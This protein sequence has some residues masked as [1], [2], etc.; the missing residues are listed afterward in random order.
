MHSETTPIARRTPRTEQLGLF[1]SPP[2]LLSP[3]DIFQNA[4]ATLLSILR[5]DRKIARKPARTHGRVIGEYHSMWA[6]TAPEG[7][8]TALGIENDGTFTG[9]AMLSNSEL[10]DREKAGHSYCPDSRSD[11]KRIPVINSLGQADFVLLLR[12]Y[13]REDKVV[14]D[15]TGNAYTRVGD[16]KHRLRDDEIQELKIDKGQV[17][18][19]QE[20]VSMEYPD[21]FRTDLIA[22]FIA[23]VQRIRRLTQLHSDE[24]ILEHRRLGK[25]QGGKF[26]PNVACALLFAKDPNALFPGCSIRFLR[27]E[28]ESEQ[29]GENYNVIKDIWLEGC[30]PELIVDIAVI[31]Q[32]QLREF[33]KLGEDGKFYT[34]PEYP[35]EA[36]YEAIVNACV[37][38]SYGLRNMNTFV[39]MFDDRLVIES[40]GAFPPFVTPQNI[41]D[42]HHPRNPHLMRAMF[43]LDFV[44]CH[45]EGTRRMRDTMASMNLPGPSFEQ[46]EVAKGFMSV[47]VTLRNNR[48]QRRVWLDSDVS[49]LVSPELAKEL[50]LEETR[51]LNFVSEHESIN[52]SECQRLLPHIKTWHSAKKLLSQLAD[53]GIL[54]HVHRKDIE[55][56]PDSCFTLPGPPTSPIR[57]AR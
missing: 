17:D 10:N 23:G 30:I 25:R 46:K 22:Q 16:E 19:E 37:H 52:V 8:I 9:C 3:D 31:L 38:R 45:N 42:S 40:P 51:V 27:Y 1:T 2:T 4:D 48:K 29:T 34:A 57:K 41:Y 11:S 43:Y 35:Q 14:C 28:G 7:G 5:E 39:K 44:K 21:D 36:W 56:D 12:T 53:R 54:V 6:N 33:S 15:V 50:T 32:S 55:R 47:R 13:Y 26:V 20:P 18:L 49:R 24:E